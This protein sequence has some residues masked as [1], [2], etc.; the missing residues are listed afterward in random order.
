MRSLL[1]AMTMTGSVFGKEP[2]TQ[3]VTFGQGGKFRAE[4]AK[5]LHMWI[6]TV[7]CLTG[8]GKVN[9]CYVKTRG[10]AFAAAA[11]YARH[12]GATEE[13]CKKINAGVLW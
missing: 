12:T 5:D 2:I 13:E 1:T 9:T 4:W 6:L 10:Q 11:D 8:N 7:P 3:T